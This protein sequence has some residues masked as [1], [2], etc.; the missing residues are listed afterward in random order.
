MGTTS[1]RPITVKDKHHVM[2]IL[3]NTPEFLPPEVIVAEELIDAFLE[4]E[5]S[6]GYHI[7]VA[8]LD[9]EIAGYVCYGD[10]PLNRSNLGF[11]LDCGGQR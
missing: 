7:Y 6:S 11:I 3:K 2:H 10:T 9:G 5:R 4:E 8:E 1:I